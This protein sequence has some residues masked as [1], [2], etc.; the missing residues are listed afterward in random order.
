MLL[1]FLRAREFNVQKAADMILQDVVCA[2]SF[3]IP[4]TIACSYRALF[5]F[6]QE[7]RKKNEVDDILDTFPKNKYFNSLFTYYPGAIHKTDKVRVG[8]LFCG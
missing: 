7:W 3:A 8:T 5:F 1:R 6:F 4:A 2:D